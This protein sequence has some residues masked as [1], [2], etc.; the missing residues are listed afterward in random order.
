MRK[1]E[2][3]LSRQVRFYRFAPRF[4]R[5]LSASSPIMFLRFRQATIG[6]YLAE[7]ELAVQRWPFTYVSNRKFGLPYDIENHDRPKGVD[8]LCSGLI[9][10]MP[11]NTELPPRKDGRTS[12][13]N[14]QKFVS[15]SG[16]SPT[17]PEVHI[18]STA[19]LPQNRHSGT[20]DVK[21]DLFGTPVTPE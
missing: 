21:S 8:L 3:Y 2:Y 6:M 13:D 11:E 19:L 9:C 1:R 18:F 7:P 4:N 20:F 17:P 14:D 5:L 12:T 15:K 16:L 10:A